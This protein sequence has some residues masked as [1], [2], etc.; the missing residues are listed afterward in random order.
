[1]FVAVF[2]VFVVAIIVLCVFT[3]RWAIVRDRE[4]RAKESTKET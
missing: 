4:R 2:S 1:M 3:L